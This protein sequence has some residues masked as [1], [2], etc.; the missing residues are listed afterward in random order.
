M[1]GLFLPLDWCWL[2]YDMRPARANAAR[3]GEGWA[4]QGAAALEGRWHWVLHSTVPSWFLIKS[5]KS[6]ELPN[7]SEHATNRRQ[8]GGEPFQ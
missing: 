7:S 3:E 4:Q 6:P 2:V 8:G 5:V 1:A